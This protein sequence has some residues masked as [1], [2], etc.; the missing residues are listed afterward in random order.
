MTTLNRRIAGDV[1][2]DF[3]VLLIGMR[4]NKLWKVHRWLPVFRG[5]P[6][7][8]DRLENDPNSGLLGYEVSLGL[9]NHLVIQ[10]W[11]SFEQLH[12]FATDGD[13]M[14]VPTW[15]RFNRTV[16]DNGDVGIWHELFIVESDRFE[17]IYR[18]VPLR[19]LASAADYVP[20]TGRQRTSSGRLGFTDGEDTLVDETG[21]LRE[22][23]DRGR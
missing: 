1:E 3:V 18:N 16:G 13:D 8:L 2:G 23:H 7:M 19:G 22:A 15:Q 5:M 10:Y 14:H 4:I 20:A 9:R 11:R 17:A 21:I 12:A 6:R